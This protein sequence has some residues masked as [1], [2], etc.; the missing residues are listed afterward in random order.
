MHL[1][2]SKTFPRRR[3]AAAPRGQYVPVKVCVSRRVTLAKEGTTAGSYP[4]SLYRADK[5]SWR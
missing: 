1:I 5:T 2:D 4:L 3:A